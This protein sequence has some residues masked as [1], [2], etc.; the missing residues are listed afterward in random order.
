[1]GTVLPPGDHMCKQLFRI[2]SKFRPGRVCSV[3]DALVR[4]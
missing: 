4:C 2:Q 3:G 1:M